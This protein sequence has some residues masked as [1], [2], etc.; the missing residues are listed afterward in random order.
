[1]NAAGPLT[2]QLERVGDADCERRWPVRSIGARL[3][4][5]QTSYASPSACSAGRDRAERLKARPRD[6]P[7]C[8]RH[9]VRHRWRRRVQ[10][11]IERRPRRL[12]RREPPAVLAAPQISRPRSLREVSTPYR[13]D[14]SG[15]VVGY[16]T[17]FELALPPDATADDLRAFFTGRLRA[18]W[19]LVENFQ[20]HVLNLAHVCPIIVGAR[21]PAGRESPEQAS[22]LTGAGQRRAVVDPSPPSQEPPEIGR[23]LVS[24]LRLESQSPGVVERNCGKGVPTSG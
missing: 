14:D 3:N 9:R 10:P 24:E 1:V 16:L 20:G 4:V 18:R 11:H 23:F 21:R 19:R 6:P 15:P 5:R 22:A 8:H 17:R 12:R 7:Q 13:E 2:A